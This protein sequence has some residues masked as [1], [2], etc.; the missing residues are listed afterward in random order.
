MKTGRWEKAEGKAQRALAL[1]PNYGA[2]YFN[3]AS[4]YLALGRLEAANDIGRQARTKVDIAASVILYWTAFLRQDTGGMQEQIN[5]NTGDPEE[6]DDLLLYAQ[7]DTEAYRGRLANARNLS[8]RAVEL[9]QRVYGKEPAAAWQVYAALRE[10]EFGNQ[11]HARAEAEA[12]MRL[13]A[14]WKIKAAA[15][16][17]LARA[18]D[19]VGAERLA[20]Q[21][22][23]SF[24]MSVSSLTELGMMYPVYV[25]GQAYLMERQGK[26]AVAEF[27]MFLDHPGIVLNFPLGALAH[28]GLA[29]AYAMQGDTAK[30]R[31]AYQD[32][33]TLWKDADPDIPIFKQ[34]K[35]EYARLQ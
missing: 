31:A 27:Q 12:A 10:S 13:A 15:A 6:E 11:K 24:P 5:R 33:L 32:F 17:G 8:L 18:G 2:N 21:L 14:N 34:A 1:G 26:E 29:R 3:L 28:L 30:S 20:V 16:L 9:A 4:I 7:S 22:D 23:Q 25:R 19:N 35:A